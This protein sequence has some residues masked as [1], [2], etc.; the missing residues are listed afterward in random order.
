M[1]E[2][3]PEDKFTKKPMNTEIDFT[4]TTSM[5]EVEANHEV[6]A[7]MIADAGNDDFISRI[8]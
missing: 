4:E 5:K 6:V 2:V 8:S 3:E 1:L 7:K